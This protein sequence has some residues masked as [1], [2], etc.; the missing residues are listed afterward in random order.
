MDGSRDLEKA[1][2]MLQKDDILVTV[3][4]DELRAQLE[5]KQN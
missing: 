5:I 4:Q 1:T 2:V 3:T